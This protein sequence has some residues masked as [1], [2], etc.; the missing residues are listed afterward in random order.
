MRCYLRNRWGDAR[1]ERDVIWGNI[2]P[3][4]ILC[5]I[6]LLCFDDIKCGNNHVDETVLCGQ[7]RTVW[8]RPYSVDKTVLC[9][10]DPTVW[11]R[12]YCVDK[13]LLCG[14]DCTVWTRPYCV[15]KTVLCGQDCTVWTRQYCVDKTV[16]CGQD[17][18]VWTSSNDAL[19]YSHFCLF[20]CKD[21]LFKAIIFCFF[22]CRDLVSVSFQSD[23]W[24]LHEECWIT[25]GVFRLKK[26]A[27]QKWR[28]G[29]EGW[30]GRE[31][32]TPKMST[33]CC[34]LCVYVD[35]VWSALNA[36]VMT[37]RHAGGN[38]ITIGEQ[39]NLC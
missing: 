11:T 25:I 5:D 38:T 33:E 23:D 34:P 15:D 7:D 9:G 16:H 12:L 20:L 13:T 24:A 37:I 39:S 29:E 18:T 22:L 19:S 28:R 31:R 27:I 32:N 26:E 14:Q 35:A 1:S 21:Y 3:L 8:T 2:W 6:S 30:R 4:V 17:R 36:L 10:Q